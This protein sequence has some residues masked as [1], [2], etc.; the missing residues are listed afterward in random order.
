MARRLDQEEPL[1]AL[2]LTHVVFNPSDRLSNVF[3]YITL[4]PIAILVAYVTTIMARREVAAILI[5]IGQLACESFNAIL[6]AWLKEKRP[7]DNLRD[8]YGMPSSHAQFMAFWA[9]YSILYLY[10]RIT[11]LFQDIP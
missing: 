6:K 3:A 8:S 1:T 11:V 10:R 2:S 7:T 9:T 5:L 4:A